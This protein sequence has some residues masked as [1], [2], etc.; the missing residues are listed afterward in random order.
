MGPNFFQ[1][2]LGRKFIEGTI[3]VFLSKLDRLNDN[4]ERLA[5]ALERSLESE[6]TEDGSSED[7]A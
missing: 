7:D 2:I 6:T 3:P 1:T 4:M 5:V